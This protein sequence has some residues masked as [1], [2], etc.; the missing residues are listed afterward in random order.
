MI[1]RTVVDAEGKAEGAERERERDEG[2]ERR[3]GKEE[4]GRRRDC[5]R[6]GR[7]AGPGCARIRRVMPMLGLIE[8]Q[9]ARRRSGEQASTSIPSSS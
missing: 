1:S 4:A 6:E 3:K 7:H 8:L 2:Q 9:G 5:W